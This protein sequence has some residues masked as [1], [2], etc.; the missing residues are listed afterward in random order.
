MKP[1]P[2]TDSK[3]ASHMVNVGGRDPSDRAA[4]ARGEITMSPD[5]IETLRAHDLAKGDALATARIAGIQAAKETSRIIPLCHPI[6]LTHVHVGLTLLPDRIQVETRVESRG[7]TG[8]EMEA[9]TATSVALLT[10]YDMA[11]GIDRSMVIHAV[12]VVDKT[13]GT[14]PEGFTDPLADAT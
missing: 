12:R 4:I 13:G 3:G 9:L 8:V 5:T 2:H 10:L 6:A 14:H 7:R 11:K 1:L